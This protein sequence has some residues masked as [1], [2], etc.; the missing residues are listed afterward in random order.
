MFSFSPT[1]YSLSRPDQIPGLSLWLSADSGLYQ[2]TGLT[3]PVTADGQTVNGWS[4]KSGTVHHATTNPS[5][6]GLIYKASVDGF[7][8]LQCG[9]GTGLV[10]GTNPDFADQ[11]FTIFAVVKQTSARNFSAILNKGTGTSA[12]LSTW[13]LM[14]QQSTTSYIL[15]LDTFYGSTNNGDAN[16]LGFSDKWE[17]VCG[18]RADSTHKYLYQNGGLAATGSDSGNALNSGGALLGIGNSGGSGN[19]AFPGYIRE[20]LYYNRALSDTERLAVEAYLASHWST[21]WP[22][23]LS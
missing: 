8:A 19:L 4:D 11:A 1:L 14:G 23:C 10:A 6:T 22:N 7:P 9:V 12:T 13:E 17:T 20:I 15:A 3:N 2:D 18:I 21:Y 5:F 16:I